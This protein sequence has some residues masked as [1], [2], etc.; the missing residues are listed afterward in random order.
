MVKQVNILDK[1]QEG[2][3]YFHEG[4]HMDELMGFLVVYVRKVHCDRYFVNLL[5]NNPG[6]SY[7]DIVTPS[8]I[9]FASTLLKNSGA[10]W[11]D[12]ASNNGK[13][14]SKSIKTLF[15][16]GMGK[17]RV[18]EESMWNEDGED[19]YEQA[20]ANWKPC[21]RKKTSPEYKYLR[22]YW[23]MWIEENGKDLIVNG[24]T[25]HKKSIHSILHTRKRE[26]TPKA[27]T[28][29]KKGTADKPK[30]KHSYDT[31]SD[32]DIIDLGNWNNQ[33]HKSNEMDMEEEEDEDGNESSEE[34]DNADG[35][36]VVGS[37]SDNEEDD[38]NESE[39]GED[40]KDTSAANK[41]R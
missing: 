23:N 26:D 15:T 7:L 28:G 13:V 34:E 20:L 41:E 17:K 3:G 21:Y 33:G 8:D 10:V 40:E 14:S 19:F 6:K 1:Y 9:A 18:L 30:K 36:P 2:L 16:S 29:S 38:D 31:D 12:K 37:S 27:A 32:D 22:D 25:L 24:E 5:V 35:V 4:D 11:K 39:K